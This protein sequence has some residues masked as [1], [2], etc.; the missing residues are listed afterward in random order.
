[1]VGKKDF[2][3]KRA[4][5]RPDLQRS[6]RRQLVGFF[7][8]D[9]SALVPESA[10]L[11]VDPLESRPMAAQGHVTT[12]HRSPVLERTFGLAMVKRGRDRVGERLHAL[13][14]G[15]AIPVTVVDPVMFD[16]E[17]GRRDG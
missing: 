11:V 2:V 6:D 9:R 4:L 17:G 15:A 5:Q 12:S 14:N 3:G 8:E 13:W 10:V 1:M 16:P 7:P